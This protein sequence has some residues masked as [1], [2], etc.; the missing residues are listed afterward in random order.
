MDQLLLFFEQMPAWQKLA[1]VMA[2]LGASWILEGSFP[3]VR[4]AYRKWRHAGANFAFLGTSLVVNAA[5]A[6]ASV[7]A[8]A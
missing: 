5:F 2:C 6:G 4:L 3:L 8:V 1:W 7:A